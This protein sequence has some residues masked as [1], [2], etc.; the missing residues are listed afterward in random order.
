[1]LH[2]CNKNVIQNVLTK[3]S[4]N[5]IISIVKQK[6]RRA[7]T[8][9]RKKQRKNNK[10]VLIH[11]IIFL[12]HIFTSFLMINNK[13]FFITFIFIFTIIYI[14]LFYICNIKIKKYSY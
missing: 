1:M 10:K 8:M 5:S 7:E 3:A 14:L 12:L 13:N 11:N 9:N 2:K 6:K 4:Y